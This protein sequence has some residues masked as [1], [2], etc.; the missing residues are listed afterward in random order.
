MHVDV[1]VRLRVSQVLRRDAGQRY[2]A[3]LQCRQH[4]LL[5][6]DEEDLQLVQ[7]DRPRVIIQFQAA[8]R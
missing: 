4:C 2:L 3:R 8:P 7:E 1:R 5:L 6:A